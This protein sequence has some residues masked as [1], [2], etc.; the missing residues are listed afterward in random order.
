MPAPPTGAMLAGHP[1]EQLGSDGTSC[2]PFRRDANPKQERPADI[3]SWRHAAVTAPGQP[4][5]HNWQED[6][7]AGTERPAAGGGEHARPGA[8]P[9]GVQGRGWRETG[10]GD[11]LGVC[12]RVRCVSANPGA[13]TPRVH[14]AAVASSLTP[15][16]R[17]GMAGARTGTRCNRIRPAPSCAEHNDRRWLVPPA[18]SIC[19]A[20]LILRPPCAEHRGCR[21]RDG[22][23]ARHCS[24]GCR[25]LRGGQGPPDS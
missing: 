14:Q 11:V 21:H 8:T 6:S 22:T 1:P 4:P 17:S 18:W 2:S 20:Q 12:T 25:P 3:G 10:H 5:P 13:R 16:R 7:R 23:H 9:L 15:E 24:G 19:P